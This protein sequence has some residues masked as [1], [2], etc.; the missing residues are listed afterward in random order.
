M[1]P[2]ALHHN[3]KHCEK[4]AIG[5]HC[6]YHYAFEIQRIEN[7]DLLQTEFKGL[8]ASLQLRGVAFSVPWTKLQLLVIT[9]VS[10]HV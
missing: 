1:K 5:D 6:R 4:M 7:K 10:R 8:P 2:S 3:K 9:A